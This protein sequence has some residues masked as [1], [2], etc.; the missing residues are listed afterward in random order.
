MRSLATGSVLNAI[1]DVVLYNMLGYEDAI[2]SQVVTTYMM[3][4][5]QKQKEYNAFA[6]KVP[7]L[8]ELITILQLATPVFITTMSKC[9]R[10][11]STSG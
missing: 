3:I 9:P 11:H 5:G 10:W 6:I 8:D 7:K 1:G 4:D 2:I